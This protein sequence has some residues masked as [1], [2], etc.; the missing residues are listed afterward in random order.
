MSQD[1]NVTVLQRMDPAKGS[2][3]QAQLETSRQKQTSLEQLAT[4]LETAIAA[5]L[6]AI[7]SLKCVASHLDSAANWGTADMLGGGMMVTMAKRSAM[8]SA[9]SAATRAKRD[10]SDFHDSLVSLQRTLDSNPSHSHWPNFQTN[11][12]VKCL[13]MWSHVGAPWISTSSQSLPEVPKTP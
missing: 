8:D 11:M 10:V 2:R 6:K 1:M 3:I 12:P 9:R 7:G 13:S 5:G 4:R